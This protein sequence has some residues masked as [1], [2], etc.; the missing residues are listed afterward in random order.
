MADVAL[1][2]GAVPDDVASQTRVVFV[3][4]DPARDTPGFLGEY[5]GQ[6]D[7]NLPSDFVGL[8]G[9][10]AQVEA[11]QTAAGVTLAEGDGTMHATT[12]LMFGPDDVARVV[13]TAG[14]T[15]G[16]IAQDLQTV[17]EG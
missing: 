17:A 6:F 12:L 15:S 13:F 3:T 16:E 11:A 10:L 8:T 4:T 9:S 1:A 14:D 7:G 5:L 2:L